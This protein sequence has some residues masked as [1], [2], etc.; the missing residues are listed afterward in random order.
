MSDYTPI[1]KDLKEILDN[2]DFEKLEEYTDQQ[3]WSNMTHEERKLLARLFIMSAE[4]D[5]KSG[6]SIGNVKNLFT[7]ASTLAPEDSFIW[8]K[9]GLIFG[10]Q[11]IPDLLEESSICLEKAVQLDGKSFDAIFAWANVLVRRGIATQDPSFFTAAEERY[12]KAEQLLKHPEE[13]LDFYWYFGLSCFLM[14]RHS[15]EAGDTH[16]AISYYRKAKELGLKR[17]HFYNDFAN[18]LVELSLLINNNDLLY[19]AIELYLYSLDNADKTKTEPHDTAVRYCNLGACYQYLFEVH[20][21]ETFFNQAEECFMQACELHPDFGNAWAFWG[22]MLL[23]AAKLWQD[24]G[25]LE[26][27]LEKL[28][29]LS[30]FADDKPLLLSRMAEAFALYGSNE[31]ELKFLTDAQ[32][33]AEAATLEG[34]EVPYTWAALALANLELGRYFGEESYFDLAVEHA[35]KAISLNEKIGMSWHVLGVAK[36]ALCE[37]GNDLK[38]I[39]EACSAFLNASKT[40]VGRFGYMWNDWGIAL[41][42]LADITRE[43]KHVQEAIEKFEQAILLHEQVNPIW[44]V[45]YG[46]A[47]DFW[48]DISDDE[49]YYE[50][51]VEVLQHALQLDPTCTQARYHLALALLHQGELANDPKLLEMGINEFQLVLQEDVEDDTAWSDLGMAYMN[52]ADLMQDPKEKEARRSTLDQAEHNFLQAIGLGNQLV[53]YNLACLYSLQENAPEAYHFLV[54]AYENQALPPISDVLED[55][56]LE[57]LRSTNHFQQFVKTLQHS[58]RQT[59]EYQGSP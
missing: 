1:S 47:L 43:K 24:V 2:Q 23:Y 12:R 19:E 55:R 27:C 10:S 38:T 41:L 49:S 6:T 26:S 50:K 22:Y 14:G 8:F 13:H 39:H 32:E 29:R 11:N 9:R 17:E 21:E 42:N 36:F 52:L 25:Y 37:Y 15:G 28:G 34:P 31:E 3:S 4:N 5:L 53:Y 44:L 30:D 33:I 35:E 56:W 58:D 20:H 7:A 46:S 40:H 59:D 57:H 48:G 18:A 54:K 51:A 45:N 16:R